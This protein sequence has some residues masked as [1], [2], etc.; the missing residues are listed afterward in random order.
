MYRTPLIGLHL[1]VVSQ[2]LPTKAS[3]AERVRSRTALLCVST[4]ATVAPARTRHDSRAAGMVAPNR[5]AFAHTP[6]SR[7]LRAFPAHVVPHLPASPCLHPHLGCHGRRCQPRLSAEAK[8]AFQTSRGRP[9]SL[10]VQGRLRRG[11]PTNGNVG[12]CSGLSATAGERKRWHLLRAQ[13]YSRS[14]QQ[15]RH[16]QVVQVGSV[17]GATQT[18]TPN[19]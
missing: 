13:R 16:A 11:A 18:G 7:A 17:R 9:A 15:N 12:T 14:T 1:L 3:L 5:S 6:P 8:L 2:H 10:P 4:R 19:A